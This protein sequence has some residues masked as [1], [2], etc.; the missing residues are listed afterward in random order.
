MMKRVLPLSLF[1]L[2]FAGCRFYYKEK[3][4][5]DSVELSKLTGVSYQ[6]IDQEVFQPKCLS[7]HGISGGVNLENYS[8][9]RKH[10]PA[11]ERTALVEKTMPKNSSLTNRQ[12]QILTAWLRA[13]APENV[14]AESPPTPPEPLKPTF[15]SIKAKI[16]D[17]RCVT[18]HTADGRA[19]GVPLGTLQEILK[20]TRDLVLPGN[21]DESGLLIAIERVDKK[22]MPPP[23]NADALLPEEIEVIRKWIEIGAPER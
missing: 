21:P 4:P 7:C 15:E 23:E 11:I 17:R 5:S 9:V 19:S 8:E 1:I 10:L 20:S 22:R 14:G 12:R 16:I 18:C 2:L 13:G 6:I 3:A